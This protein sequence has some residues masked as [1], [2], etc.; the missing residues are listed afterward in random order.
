[1]AEA[2]LKIGPLGI[3]LSGG[4][5]LRL[6]MTIPGM[7]VFEVENGKWKEGSDFRVDLDRE[8]TLPPLRILHEFDMV[9]GR[10]CLFGI[11]ADGVYH[12]FFGEGVLLRHN[13]C[14]PRCVEVSTVTEPAMLRFVLWT[15][16]AMAGA[17][18]G[19]VPIHSSVVVCNGQA[20]MCLGESGTGKSTH[21]RLWLDNIPNCHLLNDD[22]PIL[23]LTDNGVRV[24][25]SP[26]SGKTDCFLPECYPVAGLLRLE[27][28]PTNSIRRLKVLEAF[29]ALHPS[30]PP[31]L[32]HDEYFMDSIVSFLSSVIKQVPVYRMGCLPNAEAAQISH[33]T[34]LGNL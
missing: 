1:M 19:A 9:D 34:I 12:Y 7:T 4:N 20:V 6:A 22:S 8:L 23:A 17:C 21:T 5:T 25:G 28:R 2:T 16:Y 11:D 26:W 29:G 32:A 18:L 13:P 15:A 30:C 24:Y 27:Q 14:L 3:T 31:A 10:R 33:N